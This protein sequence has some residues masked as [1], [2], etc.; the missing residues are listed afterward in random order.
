MTKMRGQMAG[1]AAMLSGLSALAACAVPAYQSLQW[2]KTSEWLPISLHD[3]LLYCGVNLFP[4]VS[5]I[6]WLG[7]QK[8]AWSLL[9]M[10]LCAAFI[11]LAIAGVFMFTALEQP[12]NGKQN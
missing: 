11:V 7:V 1:W 4:S 3:G 12:A 6:G 9:T 5:E 10:P 8:L 2:L